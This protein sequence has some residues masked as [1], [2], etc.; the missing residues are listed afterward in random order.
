MCTV[1][2]N[3][4]SIDECY[5]SCST[6]DTIMDQGEEFPYDVSSDS[7]T[8]RNR[9]SFNH[10]EIRE[11]EITL[12][13]HPCCSSGPPISLSWNYYQ[14]G[15][16]EIPFE[17]FEQYRVDQRRAIHEMKIPAHIRH[18]TLRSHDVSMKEILEVQ[19]KCTLIQNQRYQTMKKL[20]RKEHMKY[21]TQRVLCRQV[22]H[23]S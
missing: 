12:G 11:Y 20:Q 2:N 8:T 9:V 23:V 22:L 3:N 17:D 21:F 7:S 13:D 1:N 10:V 18:D 5:Q 6:I 19:S 16:Q 15:H 14:Y 4:K